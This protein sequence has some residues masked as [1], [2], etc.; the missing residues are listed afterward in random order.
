MGTWESSHWS[1][2]CIS[3]EFSIIKQIEI[4]KPLPKP[5]L[6]VGM[7]SRQRSFGAGFDQLPGQP[8]SLPLVLMLDVVWGLLHSVLEAILGTTGGP[9]RPRPGRNLGKFLLGPIGRL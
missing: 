6:V 5:L 1:D 7:T 2:I 4:K 3:L 8:P 9:Q